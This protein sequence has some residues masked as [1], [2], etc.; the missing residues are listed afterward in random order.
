MQVRRLNVVHDPLKAVAMVVKGERATIALVGIDSLFITAETTARAQARLLEKRRSRAANVL[1]GASHTHGGGPIASCFECEA[2][3]AYLELVASRIAEAVGS[4]Y[5]SLHA[6]EIGRRDRAR[7]E[8]QLQSPVPDARRP[9][10]HP[11]G[12][13]NAESSSRPVLSIPTSACSRRARR[14]ASCWGSSSTSRAISPS[15]EET[16]S[17]PI[18]FTTSERP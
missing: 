3:P 9:A 14:R 16:D 7:A 6:A 8:H 18:M 17:P 2:D 5:R 15:W 12:K 1:I 11:P 4:A 10:G 13:G